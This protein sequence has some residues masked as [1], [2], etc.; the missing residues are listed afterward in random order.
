VQPVP[1]A[2]SAA[3]Q[4]TQVTQAPTQMQRSAASPANGGSPAPAQAS[5]AQASTAQASAK[6]GGNGKEDDEDWWTE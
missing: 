4:V 6:Q 3:Q 1:P 2:Q 5:T